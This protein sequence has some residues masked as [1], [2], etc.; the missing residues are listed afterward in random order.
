VSWCQPEPGWYSQTP[1]P[2]KSPTASPEVSAAS[3]EASTVVSCFQPG[4]GVY[5]QTPWPGNS[6]GDVALGVGGQQRGVGRGQLRPGA[7]RPVICPDTLVS[8]W[9][10]TT[11][12]GGGGAVVL[13][14][15]DTAP[16]SLRSRTK[17]AVCSMGCGPGPKG[18]PPAA[19][20]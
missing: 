15:T 2:E 9:P 6:L 10:T 19:V 13:R 14:S 8:N 4:P 5:C 16:L 11:G 3:D 18:P 12:A 7:Q 17:V 1:A 20:P